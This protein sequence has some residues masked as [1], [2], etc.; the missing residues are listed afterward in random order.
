MKKKL[1]ITGSQGFLGNLAKNYFANSFEISCI[2]L[3]VD[4]GQNVFQVDV[5]DFNKLEKVIEKIRPNIILHFASEIFDTYNKDKIF[6]TNVNGTHNLYKCAEKYNVEHFIFT[7]TFSIFERDYS[8]LIPEDEPASCK[9]YYGISKV[10]TERFLL[11][12]KCKMNI[13]IF[14]CPIIVDASRVHRLGVL[15][16]FLKDNCTLWI[17]GKGEN[18]LQFVSANDLFI[19]I[20]KSLNLEGK[21][22][23]NIGC[24]KISSI[25]QTFEFLKKQT[26]SKSKIRHF[27]KNIGLMFL[28]VLSKLRLINFIDYHHKIMVSNIVMDISS[29]KKELN[30]SPSKSTEQLMLDAYFY[31]TEDKNKK[32]SGSSRKPKMGFFKVIKFFSK[33]I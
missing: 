26:N 33:F 20:E 9:N 2:D 3:V 16:E 4:E 19:A 29:I 32:M 27:N 8:Y 30:F 31:Y 13:I 14:R 23:F 7:S 11:S 22:I 18:K 17:L 24:D 25:K 10:E 28:K 1:L 21:K 15:F 6:R 12:S 5:T